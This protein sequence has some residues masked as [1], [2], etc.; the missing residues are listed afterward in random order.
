MPKPQLE[1]LR[2]ELDQYALV[3]AP[4]TGIV[5]GRSVD[6]GDTVVGGSSA[7]TLFTLARDLSRMEI[8]ARVDEL[9]IGEISSDQHVRFSVDAFP[10]EEFEGTVRQVRLVPES[11][12]NVVTYTVIIDAENRDGMLL[13]E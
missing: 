11:A 5:L 10:D 2:I 7:T 9:D 12:D 6:V 4:I 1:E 13:P 8:Q 3:L